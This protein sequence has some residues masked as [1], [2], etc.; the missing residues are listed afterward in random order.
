MNI[1]N[2]INEN[3]LTINRYPQKRKLL[4]QNPLFCAIAIDIKSKSSFEIFFKNL[5]KYKKT[6]IS[7]VKKT[8]KTAKIE[9]T[10][11]HKNWTRTDYQL[12]A[13]HISSKKFEPQNLGSQYR[14]S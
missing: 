14:A 4:L 7:I 10:K 13:V 3:N 2:W 6:C 5:N 9:Q 12:L 1:I 11:R 8:G